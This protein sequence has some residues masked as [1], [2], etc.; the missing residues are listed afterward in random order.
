MATGT[1]CPELT[2]F[3]AS[4]RQRGQTG[5]GVELVILKLTPRDITQQQASKLTLYF[6]LLCVS[7]CVCKY[8][9]VCACM[10]RAGI[11]PSLLALH[12]IFFL[13]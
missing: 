9:C 3:T 13:I 5:N 4:M 12:L 11:Y 10:W 1:G 8:V 2:S 7:A 6:T